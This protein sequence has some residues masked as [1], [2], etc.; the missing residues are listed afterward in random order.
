MLQANTNLIQITFKL[1]DV[2][3]SDITCNVMVIQWLID[4][5]FVNLRNR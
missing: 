5:L 3:V 1:I 2:T 4:K